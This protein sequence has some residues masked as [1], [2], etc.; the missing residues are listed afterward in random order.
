M[1]RRHLMYA[2][3]LARLVMIP[4]EMVVILVFARLAFDVRMAGSWP[5][6]ALVSVLLLA[7]QRRALEVDET[8]PI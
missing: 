3:A 4:I 5:A 6:L 8:R 1:R 2:Q 7:P